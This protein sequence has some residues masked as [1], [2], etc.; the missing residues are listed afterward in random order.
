MKE[1]RSHMLLT[2]HLQLFLGQMYVD[3]YVHTEVALFCLHLLCSV[4][5]I[6][7]NEA[8]GDH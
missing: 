4:G 8:Q 7:M 5:Y 6:R 1:V 3:M 2:Q